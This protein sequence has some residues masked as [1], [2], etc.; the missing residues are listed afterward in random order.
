MQRIL[1]MKQRRSI[2]SGVANQPVND[3]SEGE[4]LPTWLNEE[5]PFDSDAETRLLHQP[6]PLQQ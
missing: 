2:S 6:L 3:A 4:V 1:R 5:L